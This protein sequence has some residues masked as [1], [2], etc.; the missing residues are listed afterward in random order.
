MCTSPIWNGRDD[1]TTRRIWILWIVPKVHYRQR[2]GIIQIYSIIGLELRNELSRYIYVV[3]ENR[4]FIPGGFCLNC[5]STVDLG[6]VEESCGVTLI[7]ATIKGHPDVFPRKDIR[8]CP[9]TEATKVGKYIRK[10]IV[11]ALFISLVGCDGMAIS[12]CISQQSRGPG[13]WSY[14]A[15]LHLQTQTRI[16]VLLA[17]CRDYKLC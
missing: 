2:G 9:S 17:R 3:R 4:S 11:M 16:S 10:S 8:E 12:S 15:T 1:I 14:V 7:R 5:H 6:A 13:Y